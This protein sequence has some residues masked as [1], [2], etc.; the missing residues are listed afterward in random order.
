MR[1]TGLHFCRSQRPP[2]SSRPGAPREKKW[3]PPR[4]SGG[5][6]PV[7]KPELSKDLYGFPGF[8]GVGLLIWEGC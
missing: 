2:V 1:D 6:L 7:S 3:V 5:N 8:D 4:I